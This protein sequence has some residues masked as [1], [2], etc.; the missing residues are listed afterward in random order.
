MFTQNSKVWKPGSRVV[1]KR[2]PVT[3]SGS[4]VNQPWHDIGLCNPVSLLAAA[5]TTLEILDTSQGVVQSLGSVRTRTPEEYVIN[6]R[7]MNLRNLGL[8]FGG[9]LPTAF[10]QSATPLSDVAHTGYPDSLMPI[11]DG[12]GNRVYGIGVFTTL[13]QGTTVL[14]KGTDYDYD[15]VDLAE[16]RIKILAGGAVT[17]EDATLKVTA[18]PLA[19]TGNRVII[20]DFS[21]CST[22]RGSAEIFWTDCDGADKGVKTGYY[23]LIPEQVTMDPQIAKEAEWQ[24]RL[25]RIW[26]P[27]NVTLPYGRFINYKGAI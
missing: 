5:P 10:T 22:I 24:L 17:A 26:D 2:D 25:R 18:T 20:P 11:Y 7:N 1:F 3:V 13:K 4:P 6:S 8:I 12:S 15:A 21:G 9:A 19:I 27:E 16:G 23:E 14:V